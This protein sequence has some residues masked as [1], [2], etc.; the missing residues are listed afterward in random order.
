MLRYLTVLIVDFAT[1]HNVNPA[2]VVD[3]L[4]WMSAAHCSFHRLRFNFLFFSDWEQRYNDLQAQRAAL[5]LALRQIEDPNAE[6]EEHTFEP[7]VSAFARDSAIVQAIADLGVTG[8]VD[9]MLM[10][11]IK[12]KGSSFDGMAGSIAS[13]KGWSCTKVKGDFKVLLPMDMIQRKWILKPARKDGS[14]ERA[15]D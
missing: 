15:R 12:V 10:D 5:D 9:I 14:H 3:T 1:I 11:Q 2:M 6:G 4:R 8:Q 7:V 13:A